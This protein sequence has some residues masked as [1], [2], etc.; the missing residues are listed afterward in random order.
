MAAQN[1]GLVKRSIYIV[2]AFRSEGR[3]WDAEPAAEATDEAPALRKVERM[4]QGR[5]GAV[6]LR[7]DQDL[8]SGQLDEPV[9]LKVVGSVPHVFRDEIPI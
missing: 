5:A 3:S 8:V 7:Q 2:Q 6:A 9:V 4:A 1:D